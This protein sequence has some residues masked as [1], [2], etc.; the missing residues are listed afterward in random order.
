M[1]KVLRLVGM[2]LLLWVVPSAASLGVY[3]RSGRLSV[4]AGLFK[5]FFIVV[6]SV[7]SSSV[8]VLQIRWQKFFT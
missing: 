1:L 8:P 7:M 4:S 5:L 2:G 6:F 3:D